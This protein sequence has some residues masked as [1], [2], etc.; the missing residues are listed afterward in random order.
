[1]QSWYLWIPKDCYQ[2]I[3]LY[4]TQEVS[5][6]NIHWTRKEL[7]INLIAMQYSA[8]IWYHGQDM[9]HRHAW[10]YLHFSTLSRYCLNRQ[11][12]GLFPFHPFSIAPVIQHTAI[13]C[14]QLLRSP[15]LPRL[16]WTGEGSLQQSHP[17]LF[18]NKNFE[19]SHFSQAGPPTQP[20]ECG[21]CFAF[22][23]KHYGKRAT[24]LGLALLFWNC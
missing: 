6:F 16:S 18:P 14:W 15:V 11:V 5:F 12:S 19:S 9:I 23:A 20:G 2:Q 21:E 8:P 10:F 24:R 1:M 4:S 7:L 17:S 13:K 22:R 3:I